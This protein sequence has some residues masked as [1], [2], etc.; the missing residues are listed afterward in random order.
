MNKEQIFEE[1]LKGNSFFIDYNGKHY[2]LVDNNQN[3]ITITNTTEEMFSFI[4]GYGKATEIANVIISELESV[5]KILTEQ[6]DTNIERYE[7]IIKNIST[8]ENDEI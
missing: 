4:Q 5:N 6:N 1:F 3:P 8:K 7:E 2:T